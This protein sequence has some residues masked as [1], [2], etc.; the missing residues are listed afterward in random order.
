MNS[1]TDRQNTRTTPNRPMSQPVSGTAMPFATANAVIIQVELSALTP[2]FPA[3]VGNETLAIVESSTCMNVPTARATATIA[4]LAPRSG[5][6][7][8]ALAISDWLR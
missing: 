2:K 6:G 4:R 7:G 3:I 5:A 1:K 8:A